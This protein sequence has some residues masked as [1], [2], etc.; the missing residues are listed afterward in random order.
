[1]G[2]V[3][4]REALG[5][6]LIRADSL[7]PTGTVTFLFTD[8]E[9]ST[10]LLQETGDHYALILEIHHAAMR[11]AI[12]A[13]GGVVVRTEGDSFFAVFADAPAGVSAAVNAQ[14]S[15]ATAAFPLSV[16]VR[17]RMGLHTGVG[18]LGGD[19]YIGLDVHRAA[20]IA[21]A[22]NGGQV[23]LSAAT[24]GLVEQTL[25]AGM[26]LRDLGRHRLKD[27]SDSEHIFEVVVDGV[28]ATAAPLKTLETV[29]HN[30]PTHLTSFVG[31]ESE[32]RE[33]VALLGS[34]RLLTL[35][36][37]GGT[38]KTR[39]AT[40]I[41]ANV[42][43]DYPDGVY[44]VQLAPITDPELVASHILET[45]PGHLSAAGIAPADHLADYVS[46]RSMLLVLDNFEQ[47][48]EAAPLV[49]RLL[50]SSPSTKVLVTSRLPLRV[51][52][53]QEMP[54]PPL[55]APQADVEVTPEHLANVDAVALFVERA[56]AVRPGFALDERNAGPIAELTVRLDGLPL[57]I[58]L[59]AA[60]IRTLS[61]EAILE[62][63][64]PAIL[65][66]GPRELPLR[67]QTLHD[68]IAWSYDLL[69]MEA[70][71]LLDRLSVFAG[72]AALEEINAVCGEELGTP[73]LDALEKLVE[74][75]LVRSLPDRIR[76][77]F[78]MLETIRQFAREKL[79]ARGEEEGLLR[80]H[81]ETYAQAATVAE[82][83][84]TGPDRVRWLDRLSDDHDN[85]R[86][87]LSWA[88][89]SG[90]PDMAFEMA[91]ALW[92]YFHM[93]GHLFAS[94]DLLDDLLTMSGGSAEARALAL[95]AAGG[96]AYWSGDMAT[97]RRHYEGALDIIRRL[98]NPSKL[99]YGLYN[100]GFVLGYGDDAVAGREMLEEAL[101]VF[102]RLDDQVGMATA[103]WGLGDTWAAAGEYNKAKEC[104]EHSIAIFER[105][106][107]SFGLGW[108]LFTTGDV[109][110]RLGEHESA[111]EHLERGLRLTESGDLSAVVLYLAAFASLAMAEGD[112]VRAMRLAGAMT[113]LRDE[114][115]T[116]LVRVGVAPVSGVDEAT[117]ES[118][119]GE[120]AE[121]YATGRLMSAA[122]A[123]AFALGVES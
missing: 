116:G 122:E 35:T 115:G 4:Y 76:P 60:R 40:E 17:V 28:T 70:R 100:L 9:G 95:E 58:E 79:S 117:L 73:V 47:V 106:G 24:R 91:A 23:L 30:L 89:T 88:A 72:G 71:H 42:A 38:G 111:R 81:A 14:R 97:A 113:G 59:A 29:R 96:V 119:E 110:V 68:T 82:P 61:P 87:A 123:V 93:R 121:V 19:D 107:D 8:I 74:H 65:S 44:F 22:G 56:A 12:G 84:L 49:P 67:Q 103:T 39:L 27:L 54:V 25:P 77:R 75:S 32:L 43:E 101:E 86:Q 102:V 41:A 18:V 85:F 36:G 3:V 52:G 90:E 98:G 20:R 108:A 11:Q 33:A 66:G 104:F 16:R 120:L 34:T 99:A 21:A 114:T 5:S 50:Y 6:V 55:A 45:F 1:M 46:G 112:E 83:H 94:R 63:L 7:L 13:A 51:S 37:P 57:A 62:N 92:R 15:L 2:P 64:G 31:R 26:R 53:E 109:L 118:L 78:R 10:R 48:A 105:L 80:L 69:P